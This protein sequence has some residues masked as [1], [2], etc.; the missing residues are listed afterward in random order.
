MTTLLPIYTGLI[1]GA[2]H[3]FAGPDHLAAVAPLAVDRRNKTWRIGL[4]WG[5]GHSAGVWVLALLALAFRETLPIDLLSAWGERL[6]GLVLIGI[7]LI[8][9]RRLIATRIHSHIHE[10]DGLRH[11]HIHVHARAAGEDHAIEHGHAHSALGIGLLHGLAGTAHLLGVLPALLLP[12]R[13]AAILYVIAFGA[14]SI[15]AMTAFSWIL[16]K[17]VYHLRP[18]GDRAYRLLLGSCCTAAVL[19]GIYWCYA[20]FAQIH[21]GS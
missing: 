5:A 15:V 21:V 10:H 11:A 7:G 17:L 18:W 13:L 4:S 1:A 3:V 6:V 14:G 8:G 2:G 9:M 12:S 20:A 19:L 16:G